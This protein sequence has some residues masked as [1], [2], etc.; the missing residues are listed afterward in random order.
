MYK[1]VS[2]TVQSY[3][4]KEN[5][6][7]PFATFRFFVFSFVQIINRCRENREMERENK[8]NEKK[9][10]NQH[11]RCPIC[12]PLFPKFPTSRGTKAKKAKKTTT[13]KKENATKRNGEVSRK[14]VETKNP[15]KLCNGKMQ[16]NFEHLAAEKRKQKRPNK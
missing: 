6:I 7:L 14:P 4:V 11:Q 3:I 16:R 1:E 2:K 13:I 8:T 5:K 15:T 12:F 9:K 10:K